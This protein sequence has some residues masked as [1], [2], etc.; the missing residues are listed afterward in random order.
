[1]TTTVYDLLPDSDRFHDFALADSANRGFFRQFDGRSL[2]DSW[3]PV[4]ITAADEDDELAIL[5]DFA[6]LGTIPI[7][8]AVAVSKIGS[9]LQRY[10]ELL[11]L[12][13]SRA[14]YYAY[15]VTHFVDALNE[16]ASSVTRLSAGSIMSIE[17]YAFHPDRVEDEVIF[18]LPQLRRAFVF[19]TTAFVDICAEAQLCGLCFRPLWPA[20]AIASAGT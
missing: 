9:V 8:S 3:T 19:V 7:F 17:R 4:E 16:P 15:N 11:P 2:K 18:K 1:M 20:S 10:G 5:G 12:Q 14:D 13:Y 6:L